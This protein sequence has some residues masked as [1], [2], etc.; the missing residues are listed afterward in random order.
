MPWETDFRVE[1]GA[2]LW[3]QM[4]C[5]CALYVQRGKILGF[6]CSLNNMDYSC[7]Y[8]DKIANGYRISNIMASIVTLQV[9]PPP[10]KQAS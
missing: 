8:A 6:H 2:F 10:G 7:L 1:A 9:N 4:V 5:V 3:G